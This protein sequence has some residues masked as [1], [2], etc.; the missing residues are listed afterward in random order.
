MLTEKKWWPA[1]IFLSTS[2]PS[3]WVSLSLSPSLS[4]CHSPA[5][6][7]FFLLSSL[8]IHFIPLSLFSMNT[9]AHTH[10]W[11][12][13][14]HTYPSAVMACIQWMHLAKPRASVWIDE[15]LC[16]CLRVY[17]RERHTHTHTHAPS[18]VFAC[19]YLCQSS[20]IACMRSFSMCF[21]NEGVAYLCGWVCAFPF[22]LLTRSYES[23]YMQPGI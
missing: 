5:L 3:Q 1:G 15:Q 8:C 16:A 22:C 10:A 20:S 19:L 12:L 4:S 14:T 6:C 17:E 11:Q 21:M 13:H 9:H 18:A 23:G 7:W 2:S